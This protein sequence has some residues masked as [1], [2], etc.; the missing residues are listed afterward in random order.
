[1]PVI[2]TTESFIKTC[3]ERG[4][5]KYVVFDKSVYTAAKDPITMGCK[6]CGKDFV[7]TPNK[8]LYSTG[9]GCQSCCRKVSGGNTI[10]H[11]QYLQRCI[12]KGVDLKYDLSLVKYKTSEDK[13]EIVCKV[14]SRHFS[15]K[16]ANV[17]LNLSCKSCIATSQAYTTTEFLDKIKELGIAHLDTSLVDYKNGHTK[18]KLTCTKCRTPFQ[19]TPNSLMG[20][21]NG[22]GC[23]GCAHRLCGESRSTEAKDRFYKYVNSLDHFNFSEFNY[24]RVHTKSTVI[25]NKCQTRVQL[26]PASVRRGVGCTKCRKLNLGLSYPLMLY[27]IRILKDNKEYC[28]FGVTSSIRQRMVEHNKNLEKSGYV[29]E[30]LIIHNH[31][32]V[33]ALTIERFLKNNLPIV[34]LGVSGFKT[35]ATTMNFYEVNTIL[36]Q[37]LGHINLEIE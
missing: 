28:G 18:I 31:N 12:E 25:C 4:F 3:T 5:D 30:D 34:N 23:F 27:V 10:S 29:L 24:T 13:V 14:C 15:K 21:T 22:N 7:T 33:E 19:I 11:E 35:E 37:L 17:L 20:V 16:A 36:A 26:S 32:R 8:F 9:K 1:M 2:K 6:S